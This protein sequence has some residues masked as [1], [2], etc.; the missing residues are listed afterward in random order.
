LI[1]FFGGIFRETMTTS[2][3]TGSLLANYKKLWEETTGV[4]GCEIAGVVG[5]A[6]ELTVLAHG[7]KEGVIRDWHFAYNFHTH[8]VQ[9]DGEWW[10]ELTSPPSAK[11]YFVTTDCDLILTKKG[12]WAITPGLDAG[13]HMSAHV[14]AAYL[15]FHILAD[16]YIWNALSD[17]E[18]RRRPR[19]HPR[20]Y[21]RL[22]SRCDVGRLLSFGSEE[23]WTH[24]LGVGRAYVERE[25]SSIHDGE[26]FKQLVWPADR[27][28]VAAML[29]CVDG[30]RLFNVSFEAY[31]A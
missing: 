5:P 26:F 19:R 20:I 2:E 10:C 15:Y 24:I 27:A 14:S 7:T 21:S 17:S 8:P 31:P 13:V 28:G 18:E 22:A 16:H 11:D 30:Q 12:F 25:S 4:T 9:N 6:G 3:P 29:A 1:G 23:Y